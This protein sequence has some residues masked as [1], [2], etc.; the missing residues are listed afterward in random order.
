MQNSR[1][2]TERRGV[3]QKRDKP[4]LSVY[5]FPFLDFVMKL[6]RVAAHF[7]NRRAII[8]QI[9]MDVPGTITWEEFLENAE[10]FLQLS[11][12]LSDGWELRGYK[13]I[14]GKAYV[15]RQKKYFISANSDSHYCLLSENKDIDDYLNFE[16]QQDPFEAPSVVEKVLVKEHHILWSMSYSVPV[17]YF[18]GWKS[19]FPGINPVTVE[20]AQSFAR[21]AKLNYTELSQ[22]IHPILGTPFLHLHPCFS[23]E[24]LQI[25]S[26]SKNK[27]V[28][29]LST[30]ASSA[31]GLKLLPEYC[32]LTM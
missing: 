2:L 26:K 30:V 17:L 3:G 1:Q 18:N 7:A 12:K 11:N 32:K 13:D 4:F 9:S 5:S 23:Y 16:L 6:T 8:L 29:W 28:S 15:A 24:L 27:L 31:L 22:A 25:T 19:D 20:E 21:D 10:A 14:P